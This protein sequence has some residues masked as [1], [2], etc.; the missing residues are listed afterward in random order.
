MCAIEICIPLSWT[1]ITW[2]RG[3]KWKWGIKS[4][5]H[6]YFATALAKQIATKMH[7]CKYLK[8]KIFKQHW[9]PYDFFELANMYAIL[10]SC[11][12]TQGVFATSGEHFNNFYL[13]CLFFLQH[14]SCVIIHLRKYCKRAIQSNDIKILID[15][16]LNIS[17][18]MVRLWRHNCPLYESVSREESAIKVEQWGRKEESKGK[19]RKTG[20][21]QGRRLS[22]GNNKEITF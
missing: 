1:R 2:K 6:S 16:L 15:I 10:S 9:K 18:H 14:R 5:S 17:V 21:W 11:L 22:R 20:C 19:V 7:R 4:V 3:A 12:L 13:Q 8:K